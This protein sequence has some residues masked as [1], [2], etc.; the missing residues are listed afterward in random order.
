MTSSEEMGKK[1]IKTLSGL[2]LLIATTVAGKISSINWLI[3]GLLS[4]ELPLK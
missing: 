2:G 3:T 1:F 4:P